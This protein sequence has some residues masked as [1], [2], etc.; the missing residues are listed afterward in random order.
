MKPF[1]FPIILIIALTFVNLSMSAD[2]TDDASHKVY[3]I[4]PNDT[5]QLDF[6]KNIRK[7]ASDLQVHD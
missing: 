6:L 4:F 3:R 7:S 1:L 5:D 2:T